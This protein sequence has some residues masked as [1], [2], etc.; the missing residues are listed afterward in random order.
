MCWRCDGRAAGFVSVRLGNGDRSSSRALATVPEEPRRALCCCQ[1][2]K[3]TCKHQRER[4]SCTCTAALHRQA[5]TCTHSQCSSC[6]SVTHR[7]ASWQEERECWNEEQ[8]L[9]NQSNGARIN[10]EQ[11]NGEQINGERINGERING[12][13]V[14]REQMSSVMNSLSG[15]CSSSSAGQ[16]SIVTLAQ[17]RVWGL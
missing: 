12:E 9:R 5:H 17:T 13:Q 1:R 8:M 16:Q 7:A 15:F 10:G 14:N 4:P 2:P 6:R 11:I 3:N